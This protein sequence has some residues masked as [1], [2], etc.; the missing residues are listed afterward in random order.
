MNELIEVNNNLEVIHVSPDQLTKPLAR[1]EATSLLSRMVMTVV[2]DTHR[3]IVL[4]TFST[5]QQAELLRKAC[6]DPPPEAEGAYRR[7]T[8]QYLASMEA[9][10]RHVSQKLLA[11]LEKLPADLRD[12][13]LLK[14][15]IAALRG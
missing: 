1:M 3:E 7:M 6:P 5:L 8:A 13:G 9:I 11:E 14:R 12:D 10:P 2:S 4:K 15:F